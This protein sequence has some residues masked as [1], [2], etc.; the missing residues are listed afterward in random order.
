MKQNTIPYEP[1]IIARSGMGG[2][3][4]PPTHPMY[5]FSVQTDL[6]SKKENRSSMSLQ[7]A[8]TCEY[9][10]PEFRARVKKLL[11]EWNA[12]P[13]ESKEV[14]EWIN[15]CKNHFGPNGAIEW[16]RKYY[17]NYNS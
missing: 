11:D 15:A 14:I 5:S 2:A 13:I 9:L 12:P 10:S 7:Y 16:I 1:A 8:L 4:C 3:F 17:P 6:K